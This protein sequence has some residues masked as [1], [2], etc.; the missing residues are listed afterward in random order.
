[1]ECWTVELRTEIRGLFCLAV[2]V[3]TIYVTS[4]DA[5]RSN[6]FILMQREKRYG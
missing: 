2:R 3:G 4:G 5:S 6:G 1:M